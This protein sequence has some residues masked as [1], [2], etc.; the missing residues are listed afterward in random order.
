MAE[1]VQNTE[2]FDFF[3]LLGKLYEAIKDMK[4]LSWFQRAQIAAT[5]VV[6]GLGAWDLTKGDIK[7][8]IIASLA[9]FSLHTTAM[10]QQSPSD[11]HK[12]VNAADAVAQAMQNVEKKGDQEVKDAQSGS[13]NDSIDSYINE[14]EKK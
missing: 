12:Q 6:T 4:Y 9:T 3:S 2:S 1:E 7:Y 8:T 5:T 10:F 14:M 11:V 13:V